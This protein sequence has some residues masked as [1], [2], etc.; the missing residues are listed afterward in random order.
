MKKNK[1]MAY[2]LAVALLVGGTF[3]GTKAWFSDQV[4][5][6]NGI[7]ITMGTL[8]LELIENN[9]EKEGENLGWKLFRDEEV[10]NDSLG[11]KK[12]SDED[13]KNGDIKKQHLN[14]RPGDY[15]EKTFTVKNTG[16]LDQIVKVDTKLLANG[17]NNDYFKLTIL[18]NNNLLQ[19]G[20]EFRL[21]PDET[22]TVT[23]KLQLNETTLYNHY[24]GETFD[25]EELF[26]DIT[27]TG[28]QVNA[29]ET[30]L[31]LE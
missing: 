15:F 7:I 1:T 29:D 20:N 10:I 16:S 13:S 25:F 9:A 24:Q 22:K 12:E 2:A 8:N 5:T 14:I 28:R 11:T 27:L 21:N 26:S 18:D 4:T 17:I 31:S 6:D 23:L 3:V 30:E 19:E